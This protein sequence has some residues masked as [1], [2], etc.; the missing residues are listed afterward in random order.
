M[1]FTGHGDFTI[2]TIATNHI[3]GILYVPDSLATTVL[4]DFL[5]HTVSLL[6]TDPLMDP[7]S[8]NWTRASFPCCVVTVFTDC[9]ATVVSRAALLPDVVFT[10]VVRQRCQSC[11]LLLSNQRA[12][13][14]LT[15]AHFGSTRH[16]MEKHRW[17][18]R[19]GRLP[20]VH[21]TLCISFHP[22]GR[23]LC[24]GVRCPDRYSSRGHPLN[25]SQNYYRM[26]QLP[27]YLGCDAIKLP[28]CYQHI[29]G[30]C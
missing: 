13:A 15:S 5:I 3:I 1:D 4:G 10:G 24:Q 12:S 22:E 14:R 27:R 6:I 30:T 28:G 21:V 18:G 11:L 23:N 25:E 19:G 16:G 7:Q 2:H 9:L 8:E 29:T 20:C 26:S 17:W